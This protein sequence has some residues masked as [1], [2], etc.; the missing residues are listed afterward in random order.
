[1]VIFGKV[2]GGIDND[3]MKTIPGRVRNGVVILKSWT[4]LPE[5]AAVTVVPRKS[6]IIRVATRQR[7]VVFPLVP[8]EK[9]GSIRLTG[10]GIA[11]ILEHEELA[12]LCSRSM[13]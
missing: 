3:G 10:K 12:P 7:R 13:T 8:S 5:G 4:R 6:P 9:P 2:V 11:E 1:M